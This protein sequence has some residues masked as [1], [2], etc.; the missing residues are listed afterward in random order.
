MFLK[1]ELKLRRI[2][3][4]E[5]G[6]SSLLDQSFELMASLYP[7]ESNHS[8]EIEE[9][10]DPSC[11]FIGAFVNGT[12]VGCGAVRISGD[13]SYGEIKAVYVADEHRRKGVSRV[14]MQELASHLTSQNIGTARLETGNKQPEAFGLYSGL[15]YVKCGPFGNYSPDPNSIFMEKHIGT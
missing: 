4:D 9:L 8:L 5:A 14:I 3:P 6:I 15:G 11:Y 10:K 7:A 13:R 1:E 2:E 12:P